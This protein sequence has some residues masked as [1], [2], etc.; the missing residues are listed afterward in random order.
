MFKFINHMEDD[1]LSFVQW[2]YW[3]VTCNPPNPTAPNRAAKKREKQKRKGL[4]IENWWEEKW[5]KKEECGT[6][7]EKKSY[8]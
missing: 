8:A 5:G 1:T 2:G 6:E 3:R 4:G 7:R